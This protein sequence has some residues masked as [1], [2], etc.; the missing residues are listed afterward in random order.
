MRQTEAYQKVWMPIGLRDPANLRAHPAHS[1]RFVQNILSFPWN[2][3]YAKHS[4][5]RTTISTPEDP[6][7]QI[8]LENAQPQEKLVK[9]RGFSQ[10]FG[11]DPPVGATPHKWKEMNL[12]ILWRSELRIP[13]RSLW[14]EH[15]NLFLRLANFLPALL[16]SFLCFSSLLPFLLEFTSV[17]VS[18]T[19]E[20]HAQMSCFWLP[21]TRGW[22]RNMKGIKEET[23]KQQSLAS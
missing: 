5:K 20:I 7:H 9:R 21:D 15:W 13:C 23:E 1:R 12:S 6:K 11:C 18:F 22:G 16:T 19:S 2:A 8:N 10:I 3:P 17:A 4:E 14:T